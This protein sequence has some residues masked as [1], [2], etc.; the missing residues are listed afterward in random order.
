MRR[1][2]LG[3]GLALAAGAATARPAACPAGLAPR[4][5]AE[6]FF[7]ADIPAGGRVSDADWTQFLDRE[8]TPR[9]P[10]GLT[11]W[12]AD[13]RW[14]APG[15]GQTHETSRVLW[16]ILSGKPG[17]RTRLEAVRAAYKT[18]FKQLSVLLVE[19]RECVG[20]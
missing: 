19:H 10:G 3:I 6:L 15:I 5:T 1:L 14:L 12:N 9:F 8:V 7:G 13:G 4:M 18:Q 17:E 11:T 20:F 2:I 16:L